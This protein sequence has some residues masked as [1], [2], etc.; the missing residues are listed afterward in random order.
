M[1][2]LEECRRI[3]MRRGSMGATMCLQVAMATM[4]QLLCQVTTAMGARAS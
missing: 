4:G 2:R 1:K 3:I